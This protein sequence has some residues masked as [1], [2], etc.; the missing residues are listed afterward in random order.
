MASLGV[1]FEA[2]TPLVDEASI[3]VEHLSPPDVVRCLAT[4]KARSVADALGPAVAVIGSDTIVVVA[5]QVLG[6]PTDRTDAARM[7]GQLQSSVHTVYS[8]IAVVWQG[9][10]HCDVL[11]TQVWMK[12]LYPEEIERYIDTGEPMDK[13]GAY[14]IQGVGS[15]FIEKIDGC[16]FN[17]MGMSM[18]LLEQ[19]MQRHGLSLLRGACQALLANQ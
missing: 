7:L 13:A 16:Y 2:M 15:L 11:A 12:P 18:V 10:V 17:V 3:P 1:P 19:L 4:E 9:Q 14:A 8:G 5:E 6:K